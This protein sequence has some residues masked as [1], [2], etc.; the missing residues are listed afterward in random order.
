LQARPAIRHALLGEIRQQGLAD[1]LAALLGADK[2]IFQIDT[3][4][5]AEGRKID[6]PDREAGRL[7]VPLGDLANT[8]GLSPN[9]AAPIAASVASTS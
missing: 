8:R 6:E 5:A 7:A 2:Q 1:A 4:A 3:G 9:S